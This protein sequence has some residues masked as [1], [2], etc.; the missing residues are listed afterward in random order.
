MFW[1][2]KRS[3]FVA[4]LDDALG[5]TLPNSRQRFQFVRGRS[6]DVEF[7]R[8]GRLLFVR[9]FVSRDMVRAFDASREA[10]D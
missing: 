1:T 4:M 3:E 8:G 2:P 5:E 7:W 10:K 9:I 6:V